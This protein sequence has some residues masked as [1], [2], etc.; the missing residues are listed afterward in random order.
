METLANT[1]EERTDAEPT[2]DTEYRLRWY[3]ADLPHYTG[4]TDDF[5]V[6]ENLHDQYQH[7]PTHPGHDY[8]IE[9]REAVRGGGQR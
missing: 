2:A 5:G 9:R 1:T 4:W 8:A 7:D 3:V 6:I